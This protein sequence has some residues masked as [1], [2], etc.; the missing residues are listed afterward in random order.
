MADIVW[1][2]KLSKITFGYYLN[3]GPWRNI[4]TVVSKKLTN[5]LKGRNHFLITDG[6][7][8]IVEAVTTMRAKVEL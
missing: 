1:T 8:R 7:N 2:N 6:K 3:R 4:R 5:V